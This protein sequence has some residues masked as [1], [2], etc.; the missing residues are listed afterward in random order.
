MKRDWLVILLGLLTSWAVAVNRTP[1]QMRAIAQQQLG[2]TLTRGTGAGSS[3][4]IIYENEALAV[5]GDTA[6]G[7]AVVSRNAAQ[8]PVLGVS[9]SVF[10]L[11]EAP[12]GFRWWLKEMTARL[13]SG[14]PLRTR[15]MTAVDNF[16]TTHWDQLDP[17]NGMCPRDGR[18]RCPTGC[19]ATAMAQV[20]KYYNYPAKGRGAGTYSVGAKGDTKPARINGEYDWGNMRNLY[21]ASSGTVQKTAVQQL[22]YDAGCSVNMIYTKDGSS[23]TNPQAAIAMF[24]NFSYDSLAIRYLNRAYY[25]DEEWEDFVYGELAQKRPILY[26]ANDSAQD[27]GHAFLLTGNDETGKVWVNWGWGRA[28]VVGGYDGFFEINGLTLADGNYNFDSQH[29][30]VI[31]FRPQLSPDDQDEIMSLW[32]YDEPYKL[33]VLDHGRLEFSIG[34][35]FNLHVLWF[36]GMLYYS[37]RNTA[38]NQT[39]TLPLMDL[40]TDLVDSFYGFVPDDGEDYQRDTISIESLAPGTYEFTITSQARGEKSPSLMRTE[41]GPRYAMLTKAADGS[42]TIDKQATAIRC[43]PGSA[44]VEPP[45]VYDLQGRR[46]A[47]DAIPKGIFIQN[48]RKFVQK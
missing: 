14:L 20:M 19:V 2:G 40:Q 7:F 48:G 39:E 13:E 9:R 10:S 32:C 27:A 35:F 12:D 16:V 45:Y 37:F 21:S 44:I 43:V 15:S 25:S 38:T 30:M 36:Q 33:R 29:D 1:S 8:I 34:M 23:S 47:K 41:G 24:K 17:F 26:G 28:R 42:I 5:I 4:E 3:L 22:M 6:T 31:G 46:V 11:S 18:E